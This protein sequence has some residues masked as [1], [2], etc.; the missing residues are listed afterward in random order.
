MKH[1][2]VDEFAKR[3]PLS[4]VDPRT[5]LVALI[6]FLIA[7][8]F[9]TEMK[10]I[11]AVGASALVVALVSRIPAKHL[12]M[13][14]VGALPFV[15]AVALGALIAGNPTTA[16]LISVRIGGSVLVAIVFASTTSVFD[17]IRAMQFFR[18]PR[19]FTS[20]ILLIYRFIFIFIDELERMKLARIA[21]GFSFT[22]GNLLQKRTMKI[23]AHTIGMLFIR[24]NERAIRVFDSLR[25]RGFDGTAV[26]R[27]PLKLASIDAVYGVLFG[28]NII[29]IVIIQ[30]EVIL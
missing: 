12:A 28:A 21:R 1:R 11:I 18:M 17:Q 19:I 6:F 3:S 25:S 22:R 15:V 5:K 30:L 8:A 14:F 10:A 13:N 7:A 29:F 16:V 2:H 4:N 20:M 23:I 27:R 9:A 24:A 26:T